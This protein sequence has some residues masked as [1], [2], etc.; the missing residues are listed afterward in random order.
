MTNVN[1]V[2]KEHCY[3]CFAC[4]NICPVDAI[5]MTLDDEG[6][7]YPS[8]DP[9]K[10]I[11]CS[12][13]VRVCPSLK[14]SEINKVKNV[15]AGYARDNHEHMT[16]SSGGFFSVLA[17]EVL[18]QNGVVFGAAYD[19]DMSVKHICIDNVNDLYR[20]KGSKYLQSRIEDTYNTC[21]KY[22]EAGRIVLFSGVPCQIGGLRTFL[23]KDYTNLICIDLIC[24]G[25][26]SPA[27]WKRYLAER[28]RNEKVIRINFRDKSE[29]VSN[30]R[31]TY[32]LENGTKDSERYKDSVYVHG[33]LSNFYIRPSCFNCGY[34]GTSR[35]SDITLGDFWSIKEFHPEMNGDYGTSAI[36]IHTQKGQQWFDA[37]R[38]QLEICN[39]TM[40]EAA[41][42]NESITEPAKKEIYRSRFYETCNT[43]TLD[44]V[45]EKLY[46]D[47]KKAMEQKPA[48][49][50]LLTRLLKR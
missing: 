35:T 47:R 39:A 34:K 27:V 30:A 26:P 31:I 25:V 18:K 14:Q 10:C 46:T 16:S 49:K 13:C 3:G 50:S 23:N 9:D 5:A 45:I 48:K 17:R 32:D 4:E 24:H 38:D 43:D 44:H 15:Y 8:V 36:I 20:L 1:I 21:K 7:L 29:G 40:K 2:K 33:F 11:N 22:L 6:F 12:Q 19:D 41:T 42:W 37:V 28:Y